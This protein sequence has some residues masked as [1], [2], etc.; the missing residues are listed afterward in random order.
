M[1][2]YDVERLLIAGNFGRHLDIERAIKIG[3]LPD[4]ERGKIAFIGNSSIDGATKALLSIEDMENIRQIA[5]SVTT[6]ELT[7]EPSYYDIYTSALFLPHTD[8]RL[9]PSAQF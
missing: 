5:G 4:I 9:F 1:E 6:F 2:F 7:M 8:M 3:L